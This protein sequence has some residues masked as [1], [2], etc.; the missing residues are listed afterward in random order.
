VESTNNSHVLA[1]P[2]R[3]PDGKQEATNRPSKGSSQRLQLLVQLSYELE[4]DPTFA[5]EL[6]N[7]AGKEISETAI[8]FG[9]TVNSDPLILSKVTTEAPNSAL[10]KPIQKGTPTL[11][12]YFEKCPDSLPALPPILDPDTEAK[13][14]THAGS[15]TK[16]PETQHYSYERLEYLGDAYIE[17]ITRNIA[18]ECFPQ[19]G[20][21]SLNAFC[22]EVVNNA[23]LAK[24]SLAYGFDERMNLGLKHF[25]SLKEGARKSMTKIMGDI[26]EAYCAAVIKTD[27]QNGFKTVEQWLM[28]LIKPLVLKHQNKIPIDLNAKVELAKKLLGKG[29]KVTYEDVKK[30]QPIKGGMIFYIG[31]YITGWGWDHFHLGSGE[32][33][34][35][36]EASSW[37]A[38][39]ALTNPTTAVISAVKKEYDQCVKYE[40]E[41]EGG[42]DPEKL[43]LLDKTYKEI[44]I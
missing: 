36:H 33:V 22:Q 10:V 9:K 20:E 35:K 34:S 7:F 32:G 18:Y 8:T 3:K 25:W 40:R 2:K 42:P 17:I 26:F 5:K 23:N 41:R 12:E 14:F 43:A 37:A 31:C 13:V 6:E 21:G 11:K 28:T 44:E 15:I 39:N 30:P 24:F 38:M 16:D 29:I 27:P 19:K 4:H 1:L